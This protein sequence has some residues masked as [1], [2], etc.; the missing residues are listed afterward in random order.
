MPKRLEAFYRAYRWSR[1]LIDRS[2]VY[3]SAEQSFLPGYAPRLAPGSS[4][5]DAQHIKVSLI[6]TC[7]NEASTLESWLDSLLQ[8][9]RLPDEVVICDG[10][11][12]DGTLEI[13]RQRA[14][15]FPLPLIVL[16]APGSNIAR[17]R[18]LAI[19]RAEHAV[20]ACTD[21]G[22]RLEPGWLRLLIA[23][24]ELDNE[25]ALCAGYYQVLYTNTISRL[26][27]D[28]FGV[29]LEA[30]QPQAFLPSSR[31]LAFKKS[32]WERAGGYPEWLTDAGEDTLFDYQLK[33]Q[34][35]NW[36]FV[37]EARVLWRAP[38][39]PGKLLRTFA[40]YARGDGETG[41]AAELYWYKTVEVVIAYSRRLLLL[42]AGAAMTALYWPAS[43]LFWCTWLLASLLSLLRK[44]KMHAQRLGVAFFPYTALLDVLGVVQMLAFAAGVYNR[45]RVKERQV[46]H[47][48]VEL[49]QILKN[50]QPYKDVIVYP[51]THDWGF[52]FQRPHQMA[53]AF[54]RLGYLYF[55][56]TANERTDAVFGFREVEPNLLL[57]HLPLETFH[58][59]DEPVVYLGSA[60][61]R[62]LLK[63]F[64]RPRV[65]YDH[66]DDLQVSGARP[67]DH[68]ALLNE[69]QIVLITAQG[70]QRSV[71]EQRQD[72]LML[73]N[74]VDY[75]LIQSL[76]PEPGAPLPQGWPVSD[77]SPVI[78]GYSGA[79]AAWFDYPLVDFLAKA[80]PDWQFVLLGV[81]YDGSLPESRLLENANVHWLGM[82]PYPELFSY[83][84]RF[85]V[86]II[87]FRV[88]EITLATSPIKL[89]EYMACRL[90][91]VSTALPECRRYD[92]VLLAEDSA[93]FLGM[94]DK[95]LVLRSTLAYLETIDQVA[96]SN[97]WE[98]RARAV[99][100]RLAA[101]STTQQKC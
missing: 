17:G 31:S 9:E 78:I 32:L 101:F 7:R 89:F 61:N 94:L 55:Y 52:M 40:R 36:A 84:W 64:I 42:V 58:I 25:I 44:N 76:R 30:V 41:I 33:A 98:N 29:R 49:A 59:L 60:W 87:P 46:H 26:A 57:C 92:G 50:N 15:A 43:L 38:D 74:G 86:G 6:A 53:R 35:A 73:P 96:R 75:D 13:L 16:V 28:L 68:Q 8:Q 3:L 14:P 62:T 4:T 34:P 48:Q 70:L 69:A 88:N 97:T 66:Y 85:D 93:Q 45:E 39:K 82:K 23:P 5:E 83:V 54:A 24:F 11:S 12:T 91:V 100:K 1:P 80:R 19:Q 18:N 72:T 65:I 22:C 2:Q 63:H 67:E 56:C 90:P 10:G 20:I 27:A 47:Y 79:L 37:P 81:D 99:S 51:P 77:E 71:A 95:A 21:L